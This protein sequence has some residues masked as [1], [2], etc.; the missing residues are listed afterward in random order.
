MKSPFT[1]GNSTLHQEPRTL[2]YRKEDF[3]VVYHYYICDDTKEQ[4]TDDGLDLINMNQVHNQYREKY[5]IPFPEEIR[6]VR[7]LYELSAAKMAEVLGIGINVYRNYEAGEIP[8]VSNGRLIQMIK[9]PN[10][11]RRLLY[12]S[13]NEFGEDEFGK[14]NKKIDSAMHGWN[15]T[16]QIFETRLLGEKRP[17][18]YNGYRVADLDKITNIVLFFSE[19]LRPFT[20]KMNKLLFYADFFHFKKTCFSISGLKYKAIQMGPV[21]KNYGSIYDYAINGEYI[22][23]HEVPFEKY[24]GEQ[25]VPAGKSFNK[26]IFS[27]TEL[28][29]LESVAQ[30]FA[31]KNVAEVIDLSHKEDAWKSNIDNFGIISYYHGFHLNYPLEKNKR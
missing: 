10:E 21:P 27:E 19:R 28:D 17:S 8:S 22:D 7:E 25:F 30:Y 16:Q 5:G 9:D 11:F 29:V 13:K 23:V 3:P 2:E 6:N 4:Y 1:G 26:E 14:I 18:I 20:T 12:V 31:K 24:V 15:M